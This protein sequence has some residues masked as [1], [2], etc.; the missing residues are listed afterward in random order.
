MSGGGSIMEEQR[1]KQAKQ[2]QTF[3][4]IFSPQ[5]KKEKQKPPSD[6]FFTSEDGSD[7]SREQTSSINGQIKDGKESVSLFFL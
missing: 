4:V 5:L 6:I 2:G 1:T 7:D 3:H